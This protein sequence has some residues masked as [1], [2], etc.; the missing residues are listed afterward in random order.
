MN[1]PFFI[2]YNDLG[3]LSQNTFQKARVQQQIH[4][5]SRIP[6]IE[7][8]DEIKIPFSNEKGT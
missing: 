7:K 5:I 4:L 1:M 3:V 6:R 2:A 8:P